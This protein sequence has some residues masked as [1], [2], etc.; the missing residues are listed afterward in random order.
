MLSILLAAAISGMWDDET[1]LGRGPM[2]GAGVNVAVTRHLSVE[3]EV[4]F[5]GLQRDAGYLEADAAPL[6]ATGRASFAF[7]DRSKK[8]RPFVS[9]GLSWVRSTGH[10]TFTHVAAGP[11]GQ[12]VVDSTER[13]PWKASLGAFELGAGI[14]IQASTHWAVRPEARWVSTASDPS[15]HPSGI[16]PPLWIPRAGVTLVWRGPK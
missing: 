4:D 13:V 12:P 16:E 14:E 8:V 3:G 9:A 2:V 10:L 6:V 1:F 11:G 7:R 15:F 5:A